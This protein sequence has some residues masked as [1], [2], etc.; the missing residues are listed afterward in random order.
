MEWLLA[1]P[2]MAFFLGLG[3]ISAL[4]HILSPTPGCPPCPGAPPT[5]MTAGV[6]L[7]GIRSVMPRMPA[8][9]GVYHGLVRRR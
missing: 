9:T 5:T 3:A 2:W 4:D 6:R 1:H 8:G 7:A